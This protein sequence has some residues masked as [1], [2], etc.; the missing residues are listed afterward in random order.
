MIKLFR[1]V[2][3]DRSG[4]QDEAVERA[5]ALGTRVAELTTNK[6]VCGVLLMLVTFPALA[7]VTVDTGPNFALIGLTKTFDVEAFDPS[8]VEQGQ[9]DEWKAAWAKFKLMMATDQGSKLLHVQLQGKEVW[10]PDP[11]IDELRAGTELRT[12]STFGEATAGLL[13]G[14]KNFAVI[15]QKDTAEEQALLSALTTLLVVVVLGAGSFTFGRDAN[16]FSDKISAPMK[17]L[18]ADMTAVAM[19]DYQPIR[20]EICG[21]QEVRDIQYCF[22]KMKSGLETFAK[23]VPRPVVRQITSGGREA[24]LGIEDKQ[25]SFFFC[26][27]QGFTTVC[28]AMNS[29]PEELLAFLG[30]F[31]KEMAAIVEDTGGTLIEYIGDAIL[32]TWND[33]PE[34][35][36]A[37]HAFAAASASF[38]MRCRLEVCLS[39]SLSIS[40]SLSLSLSASL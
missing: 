34:A 14:D 13:A 10:Q 4:Q 12:V 21:V 23:Y 33:R 9:S 6:V 30:D 31:F 38:R 28:E 36:V 7:V 22:I 17:V 2:N 40:L 16:A 18:C 27:I 15:N 5:D 32:A 1:T 26:D 39:L 19:L 24:V 25:M 3:K 29:Q 35:P 11:L 20:H 8:D 37:D